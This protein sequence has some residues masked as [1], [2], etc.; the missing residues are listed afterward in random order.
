MS[1]IQLCESKQ[2]LINTHSLLQSIN[3]KPNSYIVGISHL[4]NVNLCYDYVPSLPYDLILY[5][6]IIDK[7]LQKKEIREIQ[8]LING[9]FIT[10]GSPDEHIE[11]N[12]ENHTH[13]NNLDRDQ[14]LGL[15]EKCERF[16]T[17]SSCAIYEAPFLMNQENVIQI[18]NR[19]SYRSTK[20]EELK[21]G[22]IVKV[23][24]ILKKWWKDKND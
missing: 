17:N 6:P 24:E 22:A 9:P 14:F 7:D 3:K 21:T 23:V 19:N 8:Q 18:G 15:I 2:A 5:N 12:G 1:D 4:D 16:I 11:I 20:P 10:I 13:Y